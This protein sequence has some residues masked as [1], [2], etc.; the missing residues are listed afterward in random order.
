MSITVAV[1]V[2]A[3]DVLLVAAI[4][5][6][7]WLR[8]RSWR[9]RLVA[10]Q[11]RPP[12]SVGVEEV[13][14]WLG[15]IQ[16]M[17]HPRRWSLVPLPP[18]CWEVVSSLRGVAFYVL[19]SER[20]ASK[21]LSGLRAFMPGSRISDA[22]ERLAR[23][24]GW[25]I[26]G[27]L[28]MTSRVRPL[29]S[30]RAEQTS[31][32]LLASLQPMSGESEI[33]I[34]WIITSAG[35]PPPVTPNANQGYSSVWGWEK[36]LPPDTEAVYAA[37]IKQGAPLLSGVA[38]VGVAAPSKAAARALFSRVW[39]N[40][41]TLNAPGVRLRRR[42]VPSL[43]IS[44]RLCKRAYPV[45]DWP[46][47]IS[48]KEAA[49]LLG[50]PVDG[51]RLPGV[52][53]G[54]A[55]Q[56]PPAVNMS[57]IGTVVGVSNY[58]G[59]SDRR[60]AL[61]IED[62]LRHQFVLGPTGSGKS[63]LLSNMILGDIAAGYGTVA[64]DPKGDLI[65]DVLARISDQDAHRVVVLDA[66]ARQQPI[67]LNVIGGGRDEASRELLVD[68][69]L[70]VFR[71]IWADFWGPRS[72]SVCRSALTTLVHTKGL[73]GST[74]TLCELVPLLTVPAFRRFVTHQPGVPETVRGFWAR[75]EAM[76][77]G[78][79]QQVIAPMLHKVEAFTSRTPIRLMLGQSTGFDLREV[80]T[81]RK[82]VLISLAKGRLGTETANLLG[83]L[84]VSLLWQATLARVNV[85]AEKRRPAFA[86]IDE[87]ADLMRLPLPLADMFT[88]ARGL[89][90]GMIVAT[91]IL[92]QVPESIRAAFLG[93]V[94]TQA[95]F[96]IEREDAKL[97]APRFAPLT[98][99]DLQG[100]ARYEV[101]LRP[102]LD[103]VTHSP[104]TLTT[105]PLAAPLRDASDLARISR[106]RDGIPR[107]DVETALHARC[108]VSP[109]SKT[110]GRRRREQ[111]PP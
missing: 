95:T 93:T 89:G 21:L 100:L 85:P 38:R 66:S 43:V 45:I 56:L 99:D 57:D 4:V 8:A 109:D 55:R 54:V 20:A 32:A 103:G 74:M 52:S 42:L 14:G 108:T 25:R 86:Y 59:M 6:A 24:P 19:V 96:A 75:Y 81:G 69:V 87:A 16:A 105:L 111:D 90:L 65:T 84:L 67:G 1:L 47:R 98:V 110:V 70:H 28:T 72:D 50:L 73:D 104:L 97:L 63:W 30:E 18:V 92:D 101:A 53:V 31:I 61:K 2:L 68:N 40:V 77:D 36:T 3:F 5:A 34:Q 44:R 78:E 94:R 12:A 91:Q 11:L 39:N 106:A 15:H 23:R 22:P 46:L 58:P 41:H 33:C 62:R 26:A 102:C 79:Q 27:E 9:A 51:V 60:I 35:T 82:A 29:A 48:T 107:T 13:A 80:F 88:Q 64:I 7:R 83:S 49:G 71:S 10:F 17:T 37:R 76:S